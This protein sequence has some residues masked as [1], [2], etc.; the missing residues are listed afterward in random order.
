MTTRKVG[1]VGLGKLGLPIALVLAE[2]GHHVIG[3]DGNKDLVDS[4]N[5]QTYST[6]E[7]GVMER[8]A[9]PQ[10][11][12]NLV[13]SNSYFSLQDCDAA[14]VIVPTPSDET[15]KFKS[16]YVENAVIKLRETWKD[17]RKRIIVI[18]STVMP[19]TCDHIQDTL[20]A[21]SSIEIVY[22]PEFIALGSVIKNL[23]QPDSILVGSRT[24]Y[25]AN[26]HLEIQKSF[27]GSVPTSSL[28]L[29]EAE[30]TKL[31]VNC[32]VT[33]KI[34]FA[35]FVGEIADTLGIESSKGIT[36]ALGF[37]SRIGSRYLRAGLGYSGPCFPRDNLALSSWS[38]SVGLSADLALATQ[39]IN[40]RQPEVAVRRIKRRF[41][42]VTQFL[43]FGV[44]YKPFTDVIEES[45][46]VVIA[47]KLNKEGFEIEIF[48]PFIS[49]NTKEMLRDLPVRERSQLKSSK[50]RVIL[51][52]P[53][54]TVGD[55]M[56]FLKDKELLFLG[57]I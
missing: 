3:V 32:Y 50:A 57:E 4:L 49:S 5:S 41:P 24:E 22:S 42:S 29:K 34:S 45:Q 36:D 37:D 21:D 8:L 18:V 2:V 54:F 28:T 25:S 46:S 9:S 31:L 55:Y 16:D 6:N 56:E 48:D 23:L 17:D 12:K 47:R 19:G 38:E 35:N 11:T 13:L 44:A 43:I 39:Q 1:V 52:S 27:S 10:T 26:L 53:G 30:V 7:P 14:Y 15:G 33:M 40:L 20:L 51:V